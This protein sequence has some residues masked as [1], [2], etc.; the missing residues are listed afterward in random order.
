MCKIEMDV[1]SIVEDTDKTQFCP[2][3]DEWTDGQ[4]ETSIPAFNFVEVEGIMNEM[5]V[6]SMLLSWGHRSSELH[7]EQN[8]HPSKGKCG[9]DFKPGFWLA[10]RS[11]VRKIPNPC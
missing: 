11:H 2:Q 1:A 4:G 9:L 8:F 5:N 6:W 10:V 7:P 3:T